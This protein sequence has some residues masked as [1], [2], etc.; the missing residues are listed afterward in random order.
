MD[1]NK[2][3][4]EMTDIIITVLYSHVAPS[5]GMNDIGEEG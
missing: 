3:Q 5:L 2:E 1:L 4:L